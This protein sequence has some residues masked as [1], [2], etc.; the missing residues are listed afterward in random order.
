MNLLNLSMNIKL[1]QKVILISLGLLC[2]GL[3]VLGIF[4]PLLPTTVFLLIAAACFARS[5]DRLYRW[6][7]SHKW[8]G[9][10]IKNWREHKALARK[11][12][13]TILVILWMTLLISSFIGTDA[14]WVRLILL[15]VGIGVTTFILRMNTLPEN[16]T[17]EPR[18][19]WPQNDTSQSE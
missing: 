15:A 16:S 19:A 2:V 14:L 4:L 18:E 3:G 11:T 1:L 7:L 6:L 9:S 5:S 12:K 17:N 10:Y 13:I 8:F